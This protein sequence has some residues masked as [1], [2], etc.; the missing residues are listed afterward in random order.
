MSV[1]A[2]ILGRWLPRLPSPSLPTSSAV[3]GVIMENE[4]QLAWEI[5]FDCC[6]RPH[7]LVVIHRWFFSII[8]EVSF[9]NL[10]LCTSPLRDTRL[11]SP[12]NSIVD[13]Y[14]TLTLNHPLCEAASGGF[15]D[16]A[17]LNFA[18]R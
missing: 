8:G 7:L 9:A 2:L 5:S 6:Y 12:L 17:I 11:R 1:V 4:G 16:G 13:L 14:A 15:A 18:L 3:A 10:F